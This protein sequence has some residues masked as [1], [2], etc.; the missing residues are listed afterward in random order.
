MHIWNCGQIAIN[1]GKHCVRL[2]THERSIENLVDILVL[3][4]YVNNNVTQLKIYS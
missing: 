4:L 1:L 2:G 3:S